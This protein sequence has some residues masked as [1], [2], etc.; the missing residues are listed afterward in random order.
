MHIKLR[1][2][3]T[4]SLLTDSKHA[5]SHY[6]K[7]GHVQSLRVTDTDSIE[8]DLDV[9]TFTTNAAWTRTLTSWIKAISVLT[10]KQNLLTDICNKQS[11]LKE[12]WKTAEHRQN[13]KTS[14]QKQTICAWLSFDLFILMAFKAQSSLHL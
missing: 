9:R 14:W 3:L 11:K 6:W 1:L 7:G 12:Y 5:S 2:I 13:V 10:W 4:P 8:R